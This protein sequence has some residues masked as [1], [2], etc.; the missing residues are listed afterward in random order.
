M[1]TYPETGQNSD[2]DRLIEFVRW[3]SQA[4]KDIVVLESPTGRDLFY[5]ELR[6]PMLAA[7]SDVS[8][9]FD[10][11]V[12]AVEQLP[13]EVI[14]RH[15]LE[16]A[17]LEFKLGTVRT[18]S[19]LYSRYGTGRLLRRLLEAIDTLLD[20]ILDATGFGSAISEF[21]DAVRDSIKGRTQ[22][23]V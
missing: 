8:G 13:D 22:T 17:Q 7:W 3:T 23:A 1:T 2:Q 16:G 5:S 10:G 21:K 14:Q 12:L 15:G 11:L 6:D 4:L 18:S 9:R 19:R 20:S